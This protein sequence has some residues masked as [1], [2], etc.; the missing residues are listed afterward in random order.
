[1]NNL[2]GLRKLNPF[3]MKIDDKEPPKGFEKFFKKKEQRDKESKETE[4]S[5]KARS[6]TIYF[7][8]G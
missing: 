8:R 2:S 1:M 3:V 5:S 6:L 7:N 4:E